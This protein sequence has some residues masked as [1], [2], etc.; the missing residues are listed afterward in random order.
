MSVSQF[1]G[2]TAIAGIGMAGLGSAAGFTELEILS[3]AAHK[4]VADAGLKMSDIDGLATASVS[5]SMWGMP[6]AEYLGIRPGYLNSTMIG[7]SSFVAH[8]WPAVQALMD[9]TCNNVLVCYGSTQKTSTMNR[10]KGVEMRKSLD[11]QPFENP[12]EPMFPISSYALAAK[13]HMYQY[14]TTREHLAEVAVAARKWAKL[15]PLAYS[16]DDLTIEQVLNARMVSDPLT[17]RDCCLLTDGAGAFVL[18]RAP[19]AEAGPQKPVY[20]LGNATEVWHRQISCMEDLTVTSASVSAARAY[21]MAGL[22]PK[23]VD[24]AML[25]DAFTI[26]TILFLEDL[27]FCPKGEGGRFVSD[28]AIAP[29]GRLAVNTN[30]GGLSFTHPGMY[31]IF[32]I[33]EAVEQIRAQAGAR[34]QA[35]IDVAIVQGNGGTLSSQSTALLGSAATV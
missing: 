2:K 35:G 6:V 34:Q 33:I 32:L 12:Y 13:R 21:E 15:N 14:G 11:P 3:A 18:R 26:N 16:R 28:G 23:D 7:G 29:G 31:G 4:A 27:G 22:G 9:G 24:L 17:V 30:G 20:V 8:L 25:Y 10:A 1:R 5:A 19:E